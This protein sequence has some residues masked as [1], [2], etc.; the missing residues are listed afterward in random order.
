MLRTIKDN[1]LHGTT[2]QTF[3][4][5][6]THAPLNRIDDIRLPTSVGPHD[7]RDTRAEAEMGL[8]REGFEPKDV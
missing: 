1:I 4:A 8:L 3:G 2:T 6:L 5:H 7:T